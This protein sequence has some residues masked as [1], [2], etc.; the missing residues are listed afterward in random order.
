MLTKHLIVL[1]F[2]NVGLNESK[3][4]SSDSF[5]R[6]YEWIATLVALDRRAY[7]L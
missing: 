4:I 5:H 7:L 3:D 1:F 2:L 6:L